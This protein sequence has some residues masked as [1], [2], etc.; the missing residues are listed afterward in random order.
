M[1][2]ECEAQEVVQCD[3]GFAFRLGVDGIVDILQVHFA[4]ISSMF[5]IRSDRKHHEVR[6]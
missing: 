5:R 1:L 6:R 3:H 2:G 4:A